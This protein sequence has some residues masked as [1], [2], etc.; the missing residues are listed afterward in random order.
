[1]HADINFL[2]VYIFL[3]LLLG[4]RQFFIP[5]YFGVLFP[6]YAG[7]DCLYSLYIYILL[8]CCPGRTYP[9]LLL[10]VIVFLIFATCLSSAKDIYSSGLEIV[11]KV[12]GAKVAFR[13][14]NVLIR[15]PLEV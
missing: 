11:Y 12:K 7:W 15:C 6:T 5:S 8:L 4:V 2:L 3:D 13:R 9:L 14:F 10:V 1:M